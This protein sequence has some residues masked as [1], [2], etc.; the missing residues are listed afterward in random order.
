MAEKSRSGNG[1]KIARE[2]IDLLFQHASDWVEDDGERSRR[3]V[4]IAK[5]IAMKQRIR[6]PKRYRRIF[7]AHCHTI[8]RPGINSRVRIQHGKVIITC[9]ECGQRKRYP[10]VKH[11]ADKI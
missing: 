6:I 3:C 10:V 7:C 1:K 11:H 4:L 5:R 8:L 9:L 2:R